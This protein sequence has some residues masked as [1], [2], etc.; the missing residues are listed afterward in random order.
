VDAAWIRRLVDTLR[1]GGEALR[2]RGAL[3]VAE[4][5][6]RAGARFLDPGDPLRARALELLPAT[7]GLSTEMAAAVLDGMAADWT[8]ER[9]SGLLERE[10]G[11]VRALDGF[12]DGARPGVRVHAAGPAL[13][14]QIV[15]GSVPGVSAT[16]LLRSLLLKGA[17]L[18]KP[19]HG[20]RVLPVLL[21]EALREE[22]PVVADAAAVLYWAGGREAV[23]DAVL[24][25]ADTVTVYGSDSVV[26]DLRNR[27]PV[28]TRFVAYHHR[29]SLG[30]VGRNALRPERL[31]RTACAVA[32]A[33]AFFDQRG[34]VSPRTVYVE[35]AG[36]S[37]P[38]AFAR[39]LAVALASVEERLPGGALDAA[40]ASAVHQE[41][42][43][44]E[45]LAAAG[46]G[47]EVHHGGEASWTVIFDPTPDFA[48]SSVGRV[49]RVKP[50]SDADRV[51][52]LVSPFAHHLQTVGVVGLG[53][54]R[55]E[56]GRALARVGVS[57]VA[58]FDAV[59]FPPPT[60]HHDGQGP[61]VALVRWVD[62][63]DGDA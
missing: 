4:T 9:L 52:V 15:S 21:L 32:G 11:D 61:L 18:V 14:V 7:S 5:L 34:C 29:I 41:R 50:V 63:E 56:L 58:A 42:G 62:L 57:R 13:C 59:P 16:A 51:P 12:V 38:T 54:R 1:E 33:V 27:T 28:T 8:G 40:E 22:D 36:D 10:L 45:L 31:H 2:A 24:G 48:P 19:G 3:E 46:R 43:T 35:E 55:E 53:D 47:V 60:W 17:T 6:G 30:V 23:E 44:A 26:R 39:E 25:A 20:D 49:V 37:T